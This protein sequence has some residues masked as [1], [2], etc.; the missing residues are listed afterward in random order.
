MTRLTKRQHEMLQAD[1]RGFGKCIDMSEYICRD[2]L[3]ALA[4][5]YYY[6]D[7]NFLYFY[8]EAEVQS[9]RGLFGEK[10]LRN[11]RV[12][13]SEL[14][15]VESAYR[16]RPSEWSSREIEV[17]NQLAL[18]KD[19]TPQ[20]VLRQALRTYQEESIRIRNGEHKQWVDKDGKPIREICEGCTGD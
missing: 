7:A 14:A 2:T 5:A 19:L 16:I 10:R 11:S 3:I 15:L 12:S 4:V 1:E 9:K 17:I 18:D 13:V 6:E 20:G 8:N